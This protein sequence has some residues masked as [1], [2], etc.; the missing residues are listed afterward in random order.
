MAKKTNR[1]IIYK[2]KINL[3]FKKMWKL[4]KINCPCYKSRLLH[5]I[6]FC[7]IFFLFKYCPTL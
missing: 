2:T 1:K 5:I 6:F 7:L 3:E 4:K